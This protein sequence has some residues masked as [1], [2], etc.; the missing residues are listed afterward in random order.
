M[1]A[2]RIFNH[3]H[4]TCTAVG[5]KHAAKANKDIALDLHRVG[6]AVA[7]L[8][9]GRVKAE[10]INGLLAFEIDDGENIMGLNASTPG[11][12]RGDDFIENN[13]GLA[14]RYSGFSER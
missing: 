13:P 6:G 4:E 2:H 11:L 12:P 7:V 3:R 9:I 1:P 14:H 5:I 8:R 10:K